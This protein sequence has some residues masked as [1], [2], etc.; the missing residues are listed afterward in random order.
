MRG[1]PER[2]VFR[3]FF[4]ACKGS[5]DIDNSTFVEYNYSTNVEN[6]K[7]GGAVNVR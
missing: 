5:D 4:C 6:L 3:V 7:K 2:V 1:T